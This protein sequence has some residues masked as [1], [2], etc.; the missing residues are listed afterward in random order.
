MGNSALTSFRSQLT[1]CGIAGPSQSANIND[2][3]EC[4][5][6][7]QS[8]NDNIVKDLNINLD[9]KNVD[10]YE[11]RKLD[12]FLATMDVRETLN[13]DLSNNKLSDNTI[14]TIFSNISYLYK[15]KDLSIN[16]SGNSITKFGIESIC[17]KIAV[18][19]SQ[20]NV[21]S[22][23]IVMLSSLQCLDLNFSKN[24]ICE[25]GAKKI[26]NCLKEVSNLR[27]L[28]LNFEETK[29]SSSSV[30]IILDSISMLPNLTYLNLNI[31]KNGLYNDCCV[32]IENKFS[33]NYYLEKLELN[34]S[35]NYLDD[36]IITNIENL[37]ANIRRLKIFSL[38]LSE[39]KKINNSSSNN[40]ILNLIGRS[41]IGYTIKIGKELYSRK[42]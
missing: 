35:K 20:Y 40:M 3:S 29:I 27:N 39:N 26:A 16:L 38:D 18:T 21:A 2:I 22:M 11:A 12:N 28:V 30:K 13:L 25:E 9:S 42:I 41:K 34:M 23:K 5:R 36:S 10:N 37:I 19:N 8:S 17:K 4:I 15:I 1:Y 6:F 31:S 32:G 33:Q 24:K 7:M 14:Q